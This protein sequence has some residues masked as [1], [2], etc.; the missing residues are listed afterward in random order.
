MIGH[1]TGVAVAGLRTPHGDVFEML[2]V[3]EPTLAALETAEKCTS[4]LTNEI[5]QL[6]VHKERMLAVI[7]ESYI[8][9]TELANQIVRDCELGYRT[10]H[11][12]VNEF[13]LASREQEI[14]ATKAR[15]ELL[16]EAAQKVLGRKLGMAEGRLRELLDPAYFIKVTNSRGGVAPDEVARMIADRRKQLAEARARHRKR[17]EA[18]EQAQQRMVSD[19]Q[20][21]HAQSQGAA[22]PNQ[23]KPQTTIQHEQKGKP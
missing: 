14:P 7:R 10:A 18:L 5:R 15:A 8:G 3:A 20:Q 6:Q 19:L 22:D 9:A 2:Y 1:L 11:K 13:V 23:P 16:D 17:I 21:L 12:I 4:E